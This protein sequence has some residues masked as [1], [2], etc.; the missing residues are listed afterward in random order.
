MNVNQPGAMNAP[1]F[2]LGRYCSTGGLRSRD[3]VWSLCWTPDNRCNTVME[4]VSLGGPLDA[5]ESMPA[6]S[7]DGISFQ[8]ANGQPRQVTS[9]FPREAQ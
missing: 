6:G 4:Q 9:T 7:V 8:H 2:N 5:P 3:L 1:Y